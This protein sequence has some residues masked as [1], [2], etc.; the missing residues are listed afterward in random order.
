M[1]PWLPYLLSQPV[2]SRY[3]R[4]GVRVEVR[5]H[6]S[7]KRL[8]EQQ[9]R[10][11]VGQAIPSP[12]I[13]VSRALEAEKNAARAS[14]DYRSRNCFKAVSII[15]QFFSECSRACSV[16]LLSWDKVT[17]VR[18]PSGDNSKVTIW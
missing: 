8:L 2:K 9:R 7:S 1:S 10:Q 3:R 18:S 16:G 6:I 15:P 13:R 11:H 14:H 12:V 5:Q 17:R 4:G